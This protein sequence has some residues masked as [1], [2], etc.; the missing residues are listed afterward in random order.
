M[1]SYKQKQQLLKIGDNMQ[2]LG[3]PI[4][5]GVAMT[6]L[7]RICRDYVSGG[8]NMLTAQNAEHRKNELMER[9]DKFKIKYLDKI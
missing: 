8:T 3:L 9:L 4:N 1:L 6:C 7:M 5:D 2:N